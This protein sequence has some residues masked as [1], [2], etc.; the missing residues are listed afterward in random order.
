[1]FFVRILLNVVPRPSR[2][3]VSMAPQVGNLPLLAGFSCPTRLGVSPF[4]F[5]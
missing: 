2:T 4:I 1:M 5:L 3:E